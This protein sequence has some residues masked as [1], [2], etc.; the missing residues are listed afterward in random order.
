[1]KL[2]SD[3]I[4]PD[5][6]LE[7]TDETDRFFSKHFSIFPQTESEYLKFPRQIPSDMFACLTERE[8]GSRN[9]LE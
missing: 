2:E 9:I 1:M 8:N 5:L 6:C 4:S 3:S 7:C